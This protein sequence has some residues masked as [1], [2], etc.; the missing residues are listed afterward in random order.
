MSDLTDEELPGYALIHCET[1]RALFHKSH[2]IRLLKM[3][4]RNDE[5]RWVDGHY[6]EFYSLGPGVIK[7][8][9]KAIYEQRRNKVA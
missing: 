9:V 8:I 7:P 1:E 2:V 4:G 6:R 3:A 5:A